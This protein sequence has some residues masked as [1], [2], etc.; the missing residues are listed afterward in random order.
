MFGADFFH[1]VFVQNVYF[2]CLRKQDDLRLQTAAAHPSVEPA[3][4]TERVRLFLVGQ[5]Q[6]ICDLSVK[7]VHALDWSF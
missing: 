5:V 4:E 2:L 1:S 3:I 6:C 7:C